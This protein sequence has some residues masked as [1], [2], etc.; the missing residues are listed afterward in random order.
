MQAWT[1]EPCATAGSRGPS[2]S[3]SWGCLSWP[4]GF[5]SG[6]RSIALGREAVSRSAWKAGLRRVAARDC[7]GVV[8]GERPLSGTRASG[9]VDRAPGTWAYRSNYEVEAD[10]DHGDRGSGLGGAD[11]VSAA[12]F[13]Y[14]ANKH[15]DVSQ[16]ESA[17]G[18]TRA[19]PPAAVA[20]GPNRRGSGQPGRRERL[21]RNVA[22]TRAT[23][24]AASPSSTSARRGAP[25]KSP[26]T[27][28][29]GTSPFG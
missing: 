12:P 18:A 7:V 24:A 4:P 3:R 17:P 2:G 13:V 1:P 22:A 10:P 23:S 19:A 8:G 14:V 25:P 6:P 28:A 11:G 15:N 26:A 5:G 16:Y 20:G 9:V 27:V 29:T 21:R